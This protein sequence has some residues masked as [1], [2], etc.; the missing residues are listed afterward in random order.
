MADVYLKDSGR[1]IRVFNTHFDHI[2]GPARHLGADLILR[3]M[4][5]FMRYD[6]TPMIL[7]GDLNA[8]PSS[9]TVSIILE[10]PKNMAF[11]LKMLI[12]KAE[13]TMMAISIRTTD[14]MESSSIKRKIKAILTTFLCLLISKC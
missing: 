1:R 14:S 7:M 11:H 5:E 10:R 9:K 2:C 4:A 13:L 3:H 12:W 6:P 8:K